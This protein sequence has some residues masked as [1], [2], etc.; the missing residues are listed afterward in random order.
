MLQ[1]LYIVSMIFKPSLKIRFF[2]FS[3]FKT[4]IAAHKCVSLHYSSIC[5]KYHIRKTLYLLNELY[6]NTKVLVDFVQ[7]FPLSKCL[8]MINFITDIHPRIYL[9]LD[10]KII[11]SAHE[12]FHIVE[13]IKLN[14]VW[15]VT[16]VKIYAPSNFPYIVIGVLETSLPI[17]I[18]FPAGAGSAQ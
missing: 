17:C 8:I 4:K 18:I 9:V 10:I 12:N 6:R 13:C 3:F 2:S 11:R 5:R 14:V 1:C 15:I 16:K 7:T